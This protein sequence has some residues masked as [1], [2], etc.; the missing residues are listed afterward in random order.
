[1]EMKIKTIRIKP[2]DEFENE[3]RELG[4]AWDSGKK[5]G[6]SI[7]GEFFESLE[8]V[9]S[10]LTEKRL[11]LWRLIRDQK[12]GSIL[13][14]SQLAERDFRG[15]HRDVSLLVSVGLVT[16]KAGKGKR[17]DVRRPISLAHRLSLD[18]A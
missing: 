13:E 12:P 15:V 6:K 11:E 1:M 14:L 8:A 18:V 7:K 10:V 16:L 17:G 5:I 2:R 3:L 9:R 4:S